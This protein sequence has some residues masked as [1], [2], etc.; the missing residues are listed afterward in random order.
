MARALSA[1]VRASTR[2]CASLIRPLPNE[3]I[4]VREL[5]TLTGVASKDWDAGVK[6]LEREGLVAVGKRAEK[7]TGKAM[8]LTELGGG[9]A[10]LPAGDIALFVAKSGSG[11]A[12]EAHVAF[13]NLTVWIP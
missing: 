12:E 10:D 3:L 4:L 5:S 9:F 13:D 1:R 7:P 8:R 6:Q 11:T 2:L